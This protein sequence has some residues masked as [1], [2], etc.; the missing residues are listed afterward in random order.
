MP[1]VHAFAQLLQPQEKFV[2]V[3]PISLVQN[4]QLFFTILVEIGVFFDR[5]IQ[6][7]QC[8]H[9]RFC[10]FFV[11]L[12]KCR[13]E[14]DRIGIVT[15]D[16]AYL[17]NDAQCVPNALFDDR[18]A[19]Q[20]FDV[21]IC[22]L[23]DNL[24]VVAVKFFGKPKLLVKPY[25]VEIHVG[26]EH[27]FKHALA[28][29]S[30]HLDQSLARIRPP[31]AVTQTRKFIDLLFGVDPLR[32]ETPCS[33]LF[34]FENGQNANA[35]FIRVKFTFVKILFELRFEVAK[36]GHRC[37]QPIF[38]H[39]GDRLFFD[40][41]IV[42]APQEYGDVLLAHLALFA[43]QSQEHLFFPL[44]RQGL[45]IS[46]FHLIELVEH[47]EC[48]IDDRVARQRVLLRKDRTLRSH[49]CD[50]LFSQCAH[51]D[52]FF[53]VPR[54]HNSVDFLLAPSELVP[55]ERSDIVRATERQ[56]RYDLAF[57]LRK[58]RIVP[59][60]LVDDRRKLFFVELIRYIRIRGRID[61]RQKVFLFDLLQAI[62]LLFAI[63]HLFEQFFDL[64]AKIFG[65]HPVLEPPLALV[66]DIT[67]IID[68]FCLIEK[69]LVL[70]FCH[71]GC[72]YIFERPE[73]FA[74]LLPTIDHRLADRPL[75]SQDNI[76]HDRRIDLFELI[77]QLLLVFERIDISFLFFCVIG[78][79]KTEF[80]RFAVVSDDHVV[81]S[82]T[83]IGNRVCNVRQSYGISEHRSKRYLCILLVSAI[84]K[85][86][87]CFV[88]AYRSGL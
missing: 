42:L 47:S 6:L 25:L 8:L 51:V 30:A 77:E 72:K 20:I 44:D 12:F 29:V 48:L 18:R 53:K 57:L 79:G 45:P 43:T 4:L 35:L 78:R 32:F 16:L 10:R 34:V 24:T 38:R 52:L 1:R 23:L 41:L 22:E 39:P 49:P 7:E 71:I 76:I 85:Q 26:V 70:F 17:V 3:E 84:G 5:L 54:R 80:E 9:S 69:R 36:R 31:A 86:R 14:I 56:Q 62:C 67:H 28:V 11:L 68:V 2:V 88:K 27:R 73:I 66:A 33:H 19:T 65:A 83:G 63:R 50:K 13:L 75:S 46:Q 81:I 61:K 55:F 59:A 87:D 64:L 15:C 58:Q 40:R 74:M 21:V 37:R 60:L 82:L